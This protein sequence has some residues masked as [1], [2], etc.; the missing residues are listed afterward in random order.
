[1]RRLLGA[2]GIALVAASVAAAAPGGD[3]SFDPTFGGGAVLTA[4]GVDGSGGGG[5]AVQP[6]G[7]V[8]AFGQSDYAVGQTG[9]TVLRFL[10]S[11]TLDPTFGVDGVAQTP[12]T[13]PF[14]LGD[15]GVLQP[16]GKSVAAGFVIEGGKDNFA[17]VRY[18]PDGTLDPNFGTGGKVVTSV[19][20]GGVGTEAI[21]SLALQPDGKLVAL[22]SD[23]SAADDA[24]HTV[25]ARYLP[26]GTLDSTFGTD[27]VAT[28]GLA[29]ELPRALALDGNDIVVTSSYRLVRLT[30]KGAIDQSFGGGQ[31]QGG[32]N[33]PIAVEHDGSILAVDGVLAPS[34]EPALEVMRVLPTGAVDPTWKASVSVVDASGLAIPEKVLEQPDGKV[35]LIA[36]VIEHLGGISP[37]HI[38]FVR[39]NVDG[40]LDP[41]FGTGGITT[42]SL[43]FPHAGVVDAVLAPDGR[44]V[45]GG[46]AINEEL[47]TGD[48]L[49]L[50]LRTDTVAPTCGFG[51]ASAT[52]GRATFSASFE[53]SDTGLGTIAA[54]TSAGADVTMPSFTAGS[55]G[56]TAVTVEQTQSGRPALVALAATDRAGNVEECAAG[57][58]VLTRSKGNKRA[59]EQTF[60]NVPGTLASLT[61]TNGATALHSVTVTVNG[62][63]IDV[64]TRGTPTT[65]VD[66]APYLHSGATN[67]IQLA[68]DGKPGASALVTLH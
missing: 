4:V 46:S 42:T 62:T 12:F 47:T 29:N 64:T 61:L 50:V 63:A 53:D 17:L 30:D 28:L 3:G 57:A 18:M 56:A 40:S 59:D 19:G 27:G 32:G 65:S 1:M 48:F 21:T 15:T 66:L 34:G 14:A 33:S 37:S 6:D 38:A 11:G 35:L 44:L 26:D 24:G 55:Q 20:D 45:A 16:D 43:A 60:A 7:K 22:G 5:I 52:G 58:T 23:W 41:T 68:P 2:V 10:P 8:L 67:T 9:F 49:T 31:A 39:F 51:Q 54:L 13:S 25:V 36:G